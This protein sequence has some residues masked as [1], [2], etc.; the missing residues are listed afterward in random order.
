[1]NAGDYILGAI[2]KIAQKLIKAREPV[3]L[4]GEV[5]EENPIKIKVNDYEITE[6]NCIFD[7]R[8]TEQW[9]R[10][11]KPDEKEHTHECKNACS[12]KISGATAAGPVTFTCT[13]TDPQQPPTAGPT[14]D[15]THKHEIEKA[16]PEICLWRGLKKGDKVRIVRLQGGAVHWITGRIEEHIANDSEEEGGEY[17]D[18]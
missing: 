12:F 17:G 6:E 9:L 1:M 3:M 2:E 16:L 11:P 15:M 18:S 7:I 8:C 10:I 14:I 5:T 4:E 13:P